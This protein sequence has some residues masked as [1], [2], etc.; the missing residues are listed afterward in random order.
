[1][2]REGFPPGTFERRALLLRPVACGLP[3]LAPEALELFSVGDAERKLLAEGVAL[4]ARQL[5]ERQV[6]VLR[7]HADALLLVDRQRLRIQR[8]QELLLVR[9]AHHPVALD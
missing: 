5:A 6:Q 2:N 3:R 1:M 7:T 8:D 9:G 4:D